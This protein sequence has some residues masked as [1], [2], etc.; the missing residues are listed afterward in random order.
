M[1]NVYYENDVNRAAIAD[2]KVA[3]LGYGSQGHAH[4]LN[5]KESGV[6]VCVGLRETSSSV[7]KATEAG[8][9]VKSIA[10]ASAWADVIMILLPDTDQ[11]AVYEEHIAPNLNAGDALAF[12][13]GFNIRFDLIAPPAD[14]D[15]IMVA[16][17]GPGHLVR[18]TYAEGGGVPCLIAVEQDA[19]G[20]AKDLALAYADGVGGARA[21]VIETTFTEEC[22]TDLFGEQVVLCG[23]M[24][25]LVR[26]AFDTLVDAGYQPE[27]CYFECLHELK[28][29]VDLMYEQ[30][31]GGMRYSVSDTAEYGDL[32]RGPRVIDD[33]VRETMQTVLSEIQSGQ[34]AE[35]W[36]AEAHGGRENFH[37]LEAAGHE[38]RIEKVGAELR[39]M[40]P[41]ISAGKVSVQDASGG[42]G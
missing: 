6:N 1:A 19:S 36:V 23:G 31:I 3:I 7:A 37:R 17:K 2:R 21:G 40:M 9:E 41:W 24:T 28:L 22:E 39:A 11:A 14:V 29:I 20:G 5:L 10:D 4:A 27:I 32:S 30:G 26:S 25:E 15:V 16:P 42:Q 8:L 33:R 13:H 35:E 38:H 12:A 34:F 18:R